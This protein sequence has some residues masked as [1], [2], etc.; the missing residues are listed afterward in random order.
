MR[1]IICPQGFPESDSEG[2]ED[3]DEDERLS[4]EEDDAMGEVGFRR[5]LFIL[6][7]CSKFRSWCKCLIPL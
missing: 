2:S 7:G 4:D 3:E 6:E 5:S 1:C